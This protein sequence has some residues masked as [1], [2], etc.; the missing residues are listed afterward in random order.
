ME[1]GGKAMQGCDRSMSGVLPRV[2]MRLFC[3]PLGS[4]YAGYLSGVCAVS[5]VEEWGME[6]LDWVGVVKRRLVDEARNGV[7]GVRWR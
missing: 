3:T 6:V 2:W 7:V 1:E 5:G 4:V